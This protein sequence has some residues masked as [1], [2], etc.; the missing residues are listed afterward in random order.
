[1]SDTQ[2]R[3][4]IQIE[5]E[6]QK[7]TEALTKINTALSDIKRNTIDTA[8]GIKGVGQASKNV[9]S[10][11]KSL[12]ATVAKLTSAFF[13]L[14]RI[15]RFAGK[16]I[17][18]AMMYE[19]IINLFQTVFRK[20][21]LEAGEEFEFAFLERAQGFVDKISDA[22]ILDPAMLMDQQAR[23]AQMADS[24]GL[25]TKSTYLMS[26]ALT[27][28]AIDVSSL[29]NI[30]DINDA[31]RKLQSGIAGQIRPMRQWGVDISKTSLQNLALKHGIT[32]SLE[33]MSAAA[34]V[35]LR[36]L[37]IME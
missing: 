5:A 34:K 14:R 27:H 26:E 1:M 7:A 23:F 6:A 3:L 9:Q 25:V 32:D 13:A 18:S 8:E 12:I 17:K 37:A 35:Q 20:I 15:V 4:E 16:A 19:E 28:L 22:Y 24:M 29:R 31:M 36:F 21:G 2:Q 10:P 11:I 30:E 33:T